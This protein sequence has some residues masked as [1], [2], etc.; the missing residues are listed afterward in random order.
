MKM[1]RTIVYLRVCIMLKT[2]HWYL[3]YIVVLKLFL[4]SWK[5]VKKGLFYYIPLL[6][7]IY[8][9]IIGLS[10]QIWV[11]QKYYAPHV[12]LDWGSNPWTPDHDSTCHVPETPVLMTQAPKYDLQALHIASSTWPGFS[13]QFNSKLPTLFYI[14]I[15]L[16]R[17]L[18]IFCKN[19]ANYC[20]QKLIIV[21]ERT[22]HKLITLVHY[23]NYHWK[24]KFNYISDSKQ[25]NPISLLQCFKRQRQTQVTFDQ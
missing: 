14:P 18:M 11:K 3:A 8:Q 24:C 1:E 13:Y 6:L 25:E 15:F 20:N 23:W 12:W 10:V 4:W 2:I 7:H 17:K 22:E 21:S 5:W 16:E 9:Y 19:I